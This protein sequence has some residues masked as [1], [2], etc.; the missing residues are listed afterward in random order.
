MSANPA[1]DSTD[2]E[3]RAKYD[4]DIKKFDEMITQASYI[5]TKKLMPMAILLIHIRMLMEKNKLQV[6][7]KLQH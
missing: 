2:T 1:P 3:K 7:I 6:S 5:Q 4:A